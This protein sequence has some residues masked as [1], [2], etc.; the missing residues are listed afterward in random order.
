MIY[1][2]LLFR[3]ADDMFKKPALFSP[4]PYNMTKINIEKLIDTSLLSYLLYIG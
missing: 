1:C 3:V 2:P 4:F